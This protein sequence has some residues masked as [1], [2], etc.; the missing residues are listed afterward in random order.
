M[1]NFLFVRAVTLYS[2]FILFF[3]V[4]M[5]SCQQSAIQEIYNFNNF[6]NVNTIMMIGPTGTGK[7]TLVNLLAGYNLTQ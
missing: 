3:A 4:S 1:L 5:I 2:I 6:F 7:S